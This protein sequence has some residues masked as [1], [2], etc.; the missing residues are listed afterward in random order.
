MAAPEEAAAISHPHDAALETRHEPEIATR[1]AV[2]LAV[3][4]HEGDLFDTRCRWPLPSSWRARLAPWATG[5]TMSADAVAA[6]RPSK[7][8]AA[9]PLAPPSAPARRWN[10]VLSF[11]LG[12]C[13]INMEW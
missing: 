5:D 12:E 8:A 2:R 10:Y 3:L 4:V 6:D 1:H 9:A 13:T 11:G 7:S